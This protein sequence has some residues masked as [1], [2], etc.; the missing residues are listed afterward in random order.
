MKVRL[1]VKQRFKIEKNLPYITINNQVSH[2]ER[3][4]LKKE[5]KKKRWELD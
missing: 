5:E 1:V 3:K 4:E 2:K